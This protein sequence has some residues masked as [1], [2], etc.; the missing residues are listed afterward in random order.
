MYNGK[1]DLYGQMKEG[2]TNHNPTI[3]IYSIKCSSIKKS[4]IQIIRIVGMTMVQWMFG[5][6]V[7]IKVM[8]TRFFIVFYLFA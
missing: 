3:L 7:G 2:F 8:A 5:Y 1:K 6:S 4:K